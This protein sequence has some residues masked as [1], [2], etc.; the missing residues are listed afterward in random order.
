[1]VPKEIKRI[2]LDK[3][4]GKLKAP[5]YAKHQIFISSLTLIHTGGLA[6]QQILI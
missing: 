3:F 5:S 6:E 4:T 1:M 2:Y